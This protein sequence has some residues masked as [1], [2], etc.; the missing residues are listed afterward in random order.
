LW[1]AA[2]LSASIYTAMRHFTRRLISNDLPKTMAGL[3]AAKRECI[4]GMEAM[5]TCIEKN[6]AKMRME[7]RFCGV[8]EVIEE[9]PPCAGEDWEEVSLDFMRHVTAIF[10]TYHIEFWG[11]GVAHHSAPGDVELLQEPA[12]RLGVLEAN[13]LAAEHHLRAGPQTSL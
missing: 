4:S 10:F 8:R 13:L 1:A 5:M 12:L 2:L 9:D 7:L 11:L 3:W 6:W